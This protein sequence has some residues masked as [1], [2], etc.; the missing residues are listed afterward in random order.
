MA[1]PNAAPIVR[2]QGPSAPTAIGARR[3]E[4]VTE[5]LARFPLLR[6]GWATATVT[7]LG[8][9]IETFAHGLGRVPQG[10]MLLTSDSPRPFPGL[11]AADALTL[12]LD[13]GAVA[14]TCSILVW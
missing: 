3:M 9:G 1:R 10:Y 6:D 4:T 14:G 8:Y 2:R 13:F 5:A 7:T 12:Q 11:V